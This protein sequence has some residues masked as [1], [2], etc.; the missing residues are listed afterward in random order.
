MVITY[1]QH[2]D[3]RL[4]F[5]TKTN[6]TFLRGAASTI[7]RDFGFIG[8]HF[9]H[10]MAGHHVV[11]HHFCKIPFYHAEEATAAIVKVMG[12]AYISDFDTGILAAF[13][14]YQRNC[15]FVE[16]REV[17]GIEQQPYFFSI[18]KRKNP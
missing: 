12:E 1:L 6:F 9:W 5:Y 17:E 16:P 10:G 14:T 15:R 7:D 13:W 18:K 11:H 4:P 2:T 8:K 3:P